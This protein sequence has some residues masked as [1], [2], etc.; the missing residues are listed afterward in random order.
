MGAGDMGAG[1]MGAGAKVEDPR[2]LEV[3]ASKSTVSAIESMS[4]GAVA[5]RLTE[6]RAT[7]F[8]ETASPTT[9]T[10]NAFGDRVEQEKV[11]AQGNHDQCDLAAKNAFESA[12]LAA[13]TLLKKENST[14]K[15]LSEH[16]LQIT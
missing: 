2:F 6:L 1:D 13:Q 14:T 10:L 15:T 9:G 12:E 7:S 4:C 3:A 8:L 5:A 16:K 11:H